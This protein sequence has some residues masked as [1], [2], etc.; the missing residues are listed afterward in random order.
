MTERSASS[1]SHACAAP[2]DPDRFSGIFLPIPTPFRRD[3]E[4]DLPALE[5]NLSRWCATGIRG[6][7]VMGST[8][9]FPALSREEKGT[10]L[11]AV[12]DKVK[13]KKIL[14]AGTGC[15]SL[16]E[17]LLLSREAA[18]LGY[19]ALLVLPPHYYKGSMTDAA[20]E[21]YFLD[22]ADL[23]PLPLFLYNMP[24]NTGINLSPALTVRLA[25]HP[26]VAGIKDST[27]SASQLAAI[28]AEMPKDF[29]LFAGRGACCSPRCSSGAGVEH[30]PWRTSHRSSASPSTRPGAPAIWS[31]PGGCSS[32]C[33]PS[34]KR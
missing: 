28:A 34:T 2:T 21:R 14:L 11:A 18:A 10:L 19:D 27:F 30:S 24:A 1:H 25:A 3:E 16:R 22:L 31:A 13:G 15:E 4:L 8:G 12:A 6:F 7:A 20:L 26:N 5:E 29:R 9:E 23:A 32:A 17:T 33:S